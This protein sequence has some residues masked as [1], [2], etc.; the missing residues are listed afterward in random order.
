M[1]S[2]AS[3]SPSDASI[4]TSPVGDSPMGLSSRVAQASRSPW[5]RQPP[6]PSPLPE[7]GDIEGSPLLSESGGREATSGPAA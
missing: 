4:G 7:L 3:I 2:V 1:A 5:A 6:D